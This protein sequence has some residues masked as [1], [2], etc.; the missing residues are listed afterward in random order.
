MAF[1]V[2]WNFGFSP[3]AMFAKA[4]EIK[5]ALA[6][7]KTAEAA[8]SRPPPSR[9]GDRVLVPGGLVKRSRSRRHLASAWR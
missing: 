7:G 2:L 9:Y 8:A 3:E 4:V 5:T 6:T 1:M